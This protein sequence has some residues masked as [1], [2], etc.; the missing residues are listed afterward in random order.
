MREHL[1]RR[2]A[3]EALQRRLSARSRSP[4]DHS[5]IRIS[6]H[7][8]NDV[9]KPGAASPGFS[10]E[11]REEKKDYGRVDRIALRQSLRDHT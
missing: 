6:Y 3:D 5:I 10:R 4:V 8:S 9:E 7:Q 1:S 2:V 11:W